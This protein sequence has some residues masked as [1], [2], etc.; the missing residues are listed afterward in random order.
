M[1]RFREATVTDYQRRVAKLGRS[2]DVPLCD[3]AL[4]EGGA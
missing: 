2:G 1:L 3:R 4:P